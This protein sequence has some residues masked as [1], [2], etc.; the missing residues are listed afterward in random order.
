MPD[1]SLMEIFINTLQGSESTDFKKF[2]AFIVITLLIFLKSYF[3][4]IVFRN[5]Y[6][7][8]AP[9]YVTLRDRNRERER[10]KERY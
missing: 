10:E 3:G 2:C 1:E 8:K 5:Y 4:N 9:L 6:A 7:S